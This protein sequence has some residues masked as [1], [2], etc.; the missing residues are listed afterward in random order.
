MEDT[1]DGHWD[2]ANLKHDINPH[3]FKQGIG[4]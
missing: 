2:T 3:N 4:I 1:A